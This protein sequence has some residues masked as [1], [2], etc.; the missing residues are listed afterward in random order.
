MVWEQKYLRYKIYRANVGL[1]YLQLQFELMTI[2]LR[3]FPKELKG[4]IGQ[5]CKMSYQKNDK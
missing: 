5:S 3:I 2:H 4:N 1:R